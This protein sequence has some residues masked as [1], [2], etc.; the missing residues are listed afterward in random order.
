MPDDPNARRRVPLRARFFCDGPYYFITSAS[1]GGGG[2]TPQEIS[3]V[4]GEGD[5]RKVEE[6]LR[7]GVG[8]PLFFPG[9][10]AFDKRQFH[11]SMRCGFAGQF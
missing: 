5:G 7:R 11:R 2:L 9:D 4:L 6:L 8:I 1:L 3:D 10:C